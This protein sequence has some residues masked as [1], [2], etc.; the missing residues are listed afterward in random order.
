MSQQYQHRLPG[1]VAE[2]DGLRGIAIGLV[3]LAHFGSQI[4][5][6]SAATKWCQA[7]CK[8]GW[9][10]VDIFFVLS[11]FLITGILFESRDSLRYYQTFYCRRALRIFPLYYGV[12]V[13]TILALPAIGVD[14]VGRGVA[15]N[16]LSLWLYYSNWPTGIHGP[17]AFRGTVLNF[18]HL[19]S[20]A[21]EEQFYLI[22]P[23]VVRRCS[24]RKLAM[25]CLAAIVLAIPVRFGASTLFGE[26]S[27]YYL[28]VC[29]LDPLAMGALTALAVRSHSE[30]TLVRAAVCLILISA[31]VVAI[32]F[33]TRQ[34]LAFND[35]VVTSYGLSA[36][37]L[38]S[39]GILLLSY[40]KPK[41]LFGRLLRTEFLQS[42]GR[43]SYAI[44]V[45]HGLLQVFLWRFRDGISAA[46][47]NYV[48]AL[49]VYMCLA[50]SVSYLCARVSWHYESIF[51]RLKDHFK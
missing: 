13:I 36:I 7:F 24:P 46:S 50:G 3:L 16:Q 17:S 44:Y 34:G 8:S 2:L 51:L 26:F 29:R 27:P 38:T 40:L 18:S 21:I 33:I 23:F 6:D 25:V 35:S 12:L 19:W 5:A 39:C 47:G 49:A 11:G 45:F 15:N 1:R 9:I 43:Y 48:I 20:L 42:L 10:G 22:W 14:L 41:T 28:T 30:S 32:L 4:P 37:G 31:P